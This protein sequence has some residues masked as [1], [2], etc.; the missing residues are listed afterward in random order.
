VQKPEILISLLLILVGIIDCVTTV[1]GIL[2]SGAVELNPFMAGLVSTNIG[3]FLVVK[4]AATI[5]IAS[6]YILARKILMEKPNKSSK[7]FNYS[8]NLLN[9]AYASIIVFLAI[10]ITNNLSVLLV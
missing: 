1:M 10:V 4:I 3:A 8:C 6:T 9:V 2:F 7:F 5:L